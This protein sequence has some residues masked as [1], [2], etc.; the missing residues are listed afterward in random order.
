LSALRTIE[1]ARSYG[2]TQLVI[3]VKIKI[4]LIKKKTPFHKQ[5][6]EQYW[7]LCY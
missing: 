5:I 3:M 1:L 7:A 6:S 4:E 2:L